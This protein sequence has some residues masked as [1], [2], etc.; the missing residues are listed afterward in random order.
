MVTAASTVPTRRAVP[1]RVARALRAAARRAGPVRHR[2]RAAPHPP[3][4]RRRRPRRGRRRPNPARRPRRWRSPSADCWSS[5]SCWPTAAGSSRRGAAPWPP[6]APRWSRSAWPPTRSARPPTGYLLY[7]ASGPDVAPSAGADVVAAAE[8][9]TAPVTLPVSFWS[10]PLFAVGL[11]AGRGRPVAR[12]QR[13]PA[14][15]RSAWSSPASPP[16]RSAPA[17]SCSA[18]SLLD[19]AVAGVALAHVAR[20]AAVMAP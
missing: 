14:G 16:G 8:A 3:D 7:W 5:R 2:L 19:V 9:S 11:A 1:R 15:S 12:R 20:R 17:R 4:G 6:S 13:C 10:V 18:S